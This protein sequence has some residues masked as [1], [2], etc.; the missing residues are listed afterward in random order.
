MK[1]DTFAR[2]AL[3]LLVWASH[4]SAQTVEPAPRIRH[5]VTAMVTV[6]MVTYA[7]AAGSQQARVTTVADRLVTAEI[8]G[9]GF[10][11]SPRARVGLV[12]MFSQWHDPPPN[13][14]TWQLG[15]VAPVVIRTFPRFFAGGGPIIAYRSGG[16]NRADVGVLL[17]TGATF[18]LGHGFA[19]NA[20][21]PISSV[22][23]H[24]VVV[25]GGVGMGIG[26]VW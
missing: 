18:R 2:P 24:R 26:K 10:V 3:V 6:P 4:L 11:L 7:G 25:A 13:I 19:V 23:A 15:A 5:F 17:L 9:T 14:P 20:T 1:A 16:R 12:T 21:A 22:F 8:L